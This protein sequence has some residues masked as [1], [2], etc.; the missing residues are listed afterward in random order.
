M[1]GFIRKYQKFFFAIT[2][3]IVVISF[4]FFGVARNIP[5]NETSEK[6]IV[7]GHAI[8]GSKMHS[9]QIRLLSRFLASDRFDAPFLRG[10]IVNFFND[11][12]IKRDLLES[13]ISNHLVQMYFSEI[14]GELQKKIPKFQSFRPYSHPLMPQ[15][16]VEGI[17]ANF[18]PQL[19]KNLT[20]LRNHPRADSDF[21]AILAKIYVD[22]SRIQPEMLRKILYYQQ[23]QM[24]SIDPHLETEELTL[25]HARSLED[26]FGKKFI[27]LCSQFIYNAALHAKKRGFKV[28]YSQARADFMQKGYNALYEMQGSQQLSNE[29]FTNYTL[30]ILSFLGL[31]EREAVECWQQVMLFRLSLQDIAGSVSLDD[32]TFHDFFH[33]SYKEWAYD[34]YHLPSQFILRDFWEVLELQ[35]YLR[36]TAKHPGMIDLPSQSLSINQ[37]LD[38]APELIERRYETEITQTNLDEVAER[39]S[40]KEMWQWQI[41]NWEN[42]VKIFPRLGQCSSTSDE[43]RLEFLETF[44]K[45]SQLDGYSRKEIV[46]KHPEWIKDALHQQQPTSK[47][48]SIPEKGFLPIEGAEDKN[49]LISLLESSFSSGEAIETLSFDH[50]N[51][52]HI[53]VSNRK[54]E[55]E[56]LTFQEAKEKGI[57]RNLLEEK[58]QKAYQIK[59]SQNPEKLCDA[60]G[61]QYDFEEIKEELGLELFQSTFRKLDQLIT[62]I[63]GK[64]NHRNDY[65]KYRLYPWVMQLKKSFVESAESNDLT[66]QNNELSDMPAWAEQFQLTKDPKTISLKDRPNWLPDQVFSLPEQSTTDLFLYEGSFPAFIQV[67]SRKSSDQNK[68]CEKKFESQHLLIDEA[69]QEFAKKLIDEF[70]TSN[71]IHLM[72]TDD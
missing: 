71:A 28:S 18:M 23:N 63:G 58:L 27:D 55:K 14:E 2:T 69:K 72:S 11:G 4:C 32:L 42:L 16:G 67:V 59:Q 41:E 17:Y 54:A 5:S 65:A 52:Y 8:D 50:L 3:F 15:I 56:V 34:V 61:K 35:T 64:I 26:W 70:Y 13:S 9:K 24:G 19:S 10:E 51:Y 53:K 39:I 49:Q 25:F 45:Q 37:I 43:D 29:E 7:L 47:I 57:L 40:L 33:H 6:D 60:E 31:T 20:K 12:V 22:H 21:F 38:K 48:L 44:S 46:K 1:L 30:K 66:S 62:K 36:S 68:I